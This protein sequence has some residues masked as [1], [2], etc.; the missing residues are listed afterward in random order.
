MVFKLP[1]DTKEN[2]TSLV[3]VD[4]PQIGL[5]QVVEVAVAVELVIQILPDE[6]I[7][8]GVALMQTSFNGCAKPARDTKITDTKRVN[9]F[10]IL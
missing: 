4:C 7:T 6:G 3:Q 9:F 5:V 10:N 2:Q 8:I 1:L